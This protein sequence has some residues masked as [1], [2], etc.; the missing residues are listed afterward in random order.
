MNAVLTNK[1]ILVVDDERDVK[2]PIGLFLEENGYDVVLA[3]SG[4]D[5]LEEYEKSKPNLT[6]M[7]IKMHGMDGYDTFFKIHEKDPNAKVVFFTGFEKKDDRYEQAKKYG[8]IDIL[9]KPVDPDFLLKLI[10]EHA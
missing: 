4:K 9:S 6:L 1:T 7:D 8:L 5:G 2:E 3:C 10:K